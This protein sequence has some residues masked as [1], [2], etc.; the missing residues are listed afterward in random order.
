MSKN[1]KMEK[2]VKSMVVM[3][4]LREE[5]SA[6]HVFAL[7]PNFIF[8]ESENITINCDYEIYTDGS[9]SEFN[10]GSA[11]CV[12]ENNKKI[13]SKTHRIDSLLSISGRISGHWESG[14]IHL[15]YK[16]KWFE[17]KWI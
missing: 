2:L 16:R 10:V 8:I 9:K 6:A 17:W 13:I 3:W 11:F 12:F 7:E 5:S 4:L 14:F 15:I 1:L